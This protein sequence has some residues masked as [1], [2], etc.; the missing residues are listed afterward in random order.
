MIILRRLVLR[1]SYC[2]SRIY[3]RPFVMGSVQTSG[4]SDASD[5]GVR[6]HYL[7]AAM[8]LLHVSRVGEVQHHTRGARRFS[9]SSC[10][11]NLVELEHEVE[12]SPRC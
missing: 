9:S 4:G 2:A 12:I 3:I 1:H 7:I 6:R 11:I 10:V 5:A 8:F